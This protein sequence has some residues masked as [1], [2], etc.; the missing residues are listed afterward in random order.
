MQRYEGN[1]SRALIVNYSLTVLRFKDQT[2]EKSPLMLRTSLRQ[3]V[4]TFLALVGLLLWLPERA[5]AY[6]D[7]GSGALL[8]QTLIAAFV[9]AIFYFRRALIRVFGTRKRDDN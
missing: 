3:L 4:P 6:A 7:P 2:M 8:W 5:S 1:N 9:G